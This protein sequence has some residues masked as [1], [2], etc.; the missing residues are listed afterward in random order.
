M[1][2]NPARGTSNRAGPRIGEHD[3]M[4]TTSTSH[5]TAP[6][7][8]PREGSRRMARKTRRL[9]AWMVG[10]L[11]LVAAIVGLLVLGPN[12]NAAPEHFSG[13]R[14]AAEHLVRRPSPRTPA[15]SRS[16]SSRPRSRGRTSTKAGR[17]SAPNLPRPQPQGAL[18]DRREPRRAVPGRQA[19]ASHRTRSMR[20]TRGARCSVALLPRKGSGVRAQVFFLEL[21]KLGSGPASRWV[22]DNW[23]PRASAVVPR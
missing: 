6:A 11:A 7:T 18:D 2:G 13:A 15:G 5:A 20:R 1:S 23:V 10:G 9:V 8:T 21:R 12:R 19:R 22:V 14:A 16:A 17:S 4:A 3:I